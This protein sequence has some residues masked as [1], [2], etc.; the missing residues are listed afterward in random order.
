MRKR[1]ASNV[2]RF[3]DNLKRNAESG[4]P[5]P[6]FLWPLMVTEYS[7]DG[8]GYLMV[9]RPDCFHGFVEFLNAKTYFKNT[10]SVINATTNMVSAFQSLHR[11]GLSYQDLNDGN[12][13]VN[14]KNGD[15]LIC[16]NDNVAPHGESFGISGKS[17][18]MAPEVVLGGKPDANSDLFSLSVVLFLFYFLSHPLEGKR[19]VSVPCLTEAYEKRVYAKEPVFILD[20][21]N[22]SNRPVRGVHNNVIALW[23]L[24]P[25]EL[26]D[27][28]IRAFSEDVLQHSDKRITEQEWKKVLYRLCDDV[29]MCNKCGE[30]NFAS[31]AQ[32]DA[33]VCS[34][35]GASIHTPLMLVGKGYRI[36]LYPGKTIR[37]WH[38]SGVDDYQTEIGLVTTNKNNPN[39]WG[40]RN[41]SEAPWI[42][43]NP[44]G[45]NRTVSAGG[46]V[47]LFRGVKISFGERKAEIQ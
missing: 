22:D 16:D 25:D 9:L 4:A 3:F 38:I 1:K 6:S 28:F 44:N 20:P 31:M 27:I 7:D 40:L 32:G 30:E 37:K 10:S 5:A 11:K 41:N 42:V 29:T 46:V 17:R 36:P 47:P 23:P 14:P 12:F 18:Y 33:L 35:C 34:E 43:T 8:F 21:N 24:Y 15:I 39:L 19:V 26:K 13:F 45:E 2:R